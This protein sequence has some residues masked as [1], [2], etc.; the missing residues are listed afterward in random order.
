MTTTDRSL[1]FFRMLHL[2][3]IIVPPSVGVGLFDYS[4]DQ[5]RGK[6]G[7]TSRPTSTEDSVGR[8]SQSTLNRSTGHFPVVLSVLHL[9]VFN[10]QRKPAFALCLTYGRVKMVSPSFG[11]PWLDASASQ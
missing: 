3:S 4:L 8:K 1:L 6:T 5:A 9:F 11:F 2:S 7:Q 10:A